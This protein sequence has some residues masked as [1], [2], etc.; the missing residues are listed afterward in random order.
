MSKALTL[1]TI[2]SAGQPLADGSV[3][4]AEVQN[5]T[6]TFNSNFDTR[7][8]LKST[9]NLSEGTNLY[10]TDT[11]S[12]AAIS[13]T[14]GSSAYSSSTGV[15]TIPTTTAH[16]TEGTNLYYTDVRARASISASSGITYSNSTGVIGVDSSIVT[17]LTET[18][19][20]TNKTLTSPIINT[21][22][23]N[24]PTFTN[25]SIITTTGNVTV[26]G[27]LSITGNLTVSGTT[28]TIS[29]ETINLADNFISLNSNATGSPTENAGIEIN[30]GS[31]SVVSIRWNESTDKWEN[32]RDGTTYYLIPINTSELTEGTNLYYT[33]ARARAAFTAGTG[34][35]ISGGV[36]SAS[37]GVSAAEAIGYAIALG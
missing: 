8:A 18:Q 13:I 25:L 20:L 34:I 15:L 31:S 7:L 29:A 35:T 19:T 24:N 14:S 30:R 16:I 12:R 2:V 27:D 6:T 26:G 36:I 4:V 5:F 9:T 21:P 23:I 11:R 22:T 17:T 3:D 32:T 33:D 1:A 10:Y 28:T 37:A